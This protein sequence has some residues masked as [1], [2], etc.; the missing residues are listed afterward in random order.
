LCAEAVYS[1]REVTP[2]SASRERDCPQG[3]PH[4][5]PTLRLKRRQ[6][7]A[8]THAKGSGARSRTGWQFRFFLERRQE[9]GYFNFVSILLALIPKNYKNNQVPVYHFLK[10]KK[11]E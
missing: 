7:G 3:V 10:G 2:T 5:H 6:R 4:G 9:C 1:S 11:G 8:R